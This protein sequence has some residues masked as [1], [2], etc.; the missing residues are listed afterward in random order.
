MVVG[1][2]RGDRETGSV[3]GGADARYVVNGLLAA[4]QELLRTKST[5]VYD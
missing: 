3:A 1:W 2:G 4:L 5:H